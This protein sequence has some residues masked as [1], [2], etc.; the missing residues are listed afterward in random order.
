M[1][2]LDPRLAADTRS[3][4]ETPD[5]WIRWMNDQRFAWLVIVPKREGVREWYELESSLQHDLLD[6]VNRCALNLQSL[7]GAFK[8]NVG[9]LGNVV[10]Q[11]HVHIIARHE[12]DPCWPGPVWGSGAVE[13]YSDG[14]EPV[15]L[16]VMRQRLS[17]RC[18]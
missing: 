1:A 8:I 11:L 3:L 2:E 5:C 14:D 10:P 4:G 15:W 6:L 7:T 9:A 17:Y 13:P 12:A 16:D 18:A